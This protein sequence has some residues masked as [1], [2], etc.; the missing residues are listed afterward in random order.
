M[1]SGLMSSRGG[2][3]PRWSRRTH[4]LFFESLDR[5]IEVASYTVQGDSFVAQ[6]AHVWSQKVLGNNRHFPGL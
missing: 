6:K 4:Q 5:H 1:E 3:S 2:L